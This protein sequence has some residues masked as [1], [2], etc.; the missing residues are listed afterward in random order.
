MP[1]AL[2]ARK[3]GWGWMLWVALA[4]MAQVLVV[5]SSSSSKVLL[6]LASMQMSSLLWVR[7]LLPLHVV[8]LWQL[9]S[10][11]KLAGQLQLVAG[12]QVLL[13]TPL[14]PCPCARLPAQDSR[15]DSRLAAHCVGC[16]CSLLTS[17]AAGSSCVVAR[18]IA[19]SCMHTRAR[20]T[21]R[22]IVP[23]GCCV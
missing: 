4:A 18:H 17:C 20:I 3:A 13:T 1:W 15:W 14:R 2:V 9:D 22:A 7:L 23:S 21:P 12:Q 6:P 8:V 5:P 19:A 10:S 16:L 11:S